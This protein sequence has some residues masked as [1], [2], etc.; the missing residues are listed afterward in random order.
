MP[1]D[2]LLFALIGGVICAFA[3]ATILSEVERTFTG[4]LLGFFFGPIGLVIAWAMRSNKLAEEERRRRQHH[5]IDDYLR[6]MKATSSPLAP[7]SMSPVEE[8]ERL[9]GLRERG[10]IT[11]EE[12]NQ[13]KAQILGGAQRTSA[14]RFR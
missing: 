11:D 5:P 1:D 7:Q 8:L 14:Q 4:V 13:A 9:A 3:G 10:H 12:F 6:A 2:F